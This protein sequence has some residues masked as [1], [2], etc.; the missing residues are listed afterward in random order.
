MTEKNR[1]LHNQFDAEASASSLSDSTVAKPIFSGVSIFV[2]G[3]TV[4]SNQVILFFIYHFVDS[5]YLF[6]ILECVNGRKVSQL[7][8]VTVSWLR[9]QL[10]QEIVIF[11]QILL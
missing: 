5:V 4:P 9:D 3:F 7:Y 8:E 1:K 6:P 10:C 2:D 11:S